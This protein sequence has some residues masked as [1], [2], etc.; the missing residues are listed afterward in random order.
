MSTND[1]A[2]ALTGSMRDF[3]EPQG[4]N[5]MA[6]V[7]PF[8]DWQETRRQRNLWPFSKSTQKAPLSVCTAADDSGTN[9]TGLNFGKILIAVEACYL[10]MSNQ[11]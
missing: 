10:F 8:H 1:L 4:A 7:K 9:F 11:N 2:Q 3:R 5:L 6:R